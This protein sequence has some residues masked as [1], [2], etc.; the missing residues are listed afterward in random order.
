MIR[1]FRCKYTEKLYNGEFV[2]QFS[3]FDNQA[4]SKLRH[5]DAAKILKDLQILSSNRFEKLKGDRKGQ[6]SIRVNKQ[7]RI[8]FKWD[9]A[10]YDVEIVDYH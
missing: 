7:W 2:R 6:Y 10:P 8:C 9:D 4:R 1:S 3:G 5:L